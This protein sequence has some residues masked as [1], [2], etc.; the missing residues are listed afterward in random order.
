MMFIDIYI[1]YCLNGQGPSYRG[2]GNFYLLGDGERIGR[3]YYENQSFSPWI[4]FSSLRSLKLSSKRLTKLVNIV[5]NCNL[6]I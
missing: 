1:Y 6:A 4:I 2:R 3:P 5:L